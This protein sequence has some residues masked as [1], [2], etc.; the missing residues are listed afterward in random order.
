MYIGIFARGGPWAPVN[1]LSCILLPGGVKDSLQFEIDLIWP[2]ATNSE[3]PF[4]SKDMSGNILHIHIYIYIY[5]YIYT[6][7]R[8][9]TL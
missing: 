6:N 3:N 1:V 4:I 9:R 2:S 8:L 7:L 5:I